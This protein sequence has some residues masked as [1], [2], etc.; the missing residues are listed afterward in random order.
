MDKKFEVNV[1]CQIE[2]IAKVSLLDIPPEEG[3]RCE[4]QNPFT[5]VKATPENS[6][7]L[8]N[9][10]G[11]VSASDIIPGTERSSPNQEESAKNIHHQDSIKEQKGI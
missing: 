5:R 10:R 8:L 2:A 4:L 1:Q 3:P 9:W 11:E 7:D 6:S